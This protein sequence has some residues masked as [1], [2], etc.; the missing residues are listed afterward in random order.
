MSGAGKELGAVEGFD[1][2][3]GFDRIKAFADRP[4]SWP[5]RMRTWCGR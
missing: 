3:E 1:G 5:T 4:A 2:L